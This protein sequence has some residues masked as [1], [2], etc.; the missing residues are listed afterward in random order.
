M[1]KDQHTVIAALC[2]CVCLSGV[3]TLVQNWPAPAGPVP[4]SWDPT[5]SVPTPLDLNAASVAQL[6]TLPGIG[7]KLAQRI[8][9]FRERLGK[10]HSV[11]QLK[12]VPGVGEK[13]LSKLRPFLVVH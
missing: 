9:E 12:E 7:P 13:L 10:F 1:W 3:W 8:V 2:I 4:A 11:E 6:E 5:R